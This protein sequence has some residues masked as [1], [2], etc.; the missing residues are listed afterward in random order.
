MEGGVEGQ[1]WSSRRMFAESVAERK[2]RRRL[3]GRFGTTRAVGS[4]TS[5]T[6][7]EIVDGVMEANGQ[8]NNGDV[9]DAN[10][11]TESWMKKR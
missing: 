5:D 3:C 4:D 11:S 9:K 6:W 7:D 8:G 1:G 10:A 2:T